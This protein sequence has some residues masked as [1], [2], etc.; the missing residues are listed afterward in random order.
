MRFSI[1]AVLMAF[2]ALL[3]LALASPTALALA[4]PQS[5]SS[6]A[7]AVDHA[8]AVQDDVVALGKKDYDKGYKHGYKDHCKKDGHLV[9]AA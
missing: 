2:V 4:G 3:T 1:R 9:L 8:A 7:A 6:T 5:K